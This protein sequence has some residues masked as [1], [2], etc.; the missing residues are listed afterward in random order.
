VKD[1]TNNKRA[2]LPE[3]MR[4][5]YENTPLGGVMY[6]LHER[7]QKLRDRKGLLAG[8]E[9]VCIFPAAVFIF[10]VSELCEI[11]YYVTSELRELLLREPYLRPL[12]DRL[13]SKEP[14]ASLLR[15]AQYLYS[16]KT[17]EKTFEPLIADW[18]TEYLEALGR[19]HNLKARWI[20]AR[21]TYSFVMVMALSKVYSLLKS[22]RSAEK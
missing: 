12:H 11:I 19:G 3:E 15:I 1:E 5:L 14:G 16:P 7:N 4:E 6:F 10:L 13:I 22:L 18:R 17:I 21:Y 8:L 9:I 2:L 20:S